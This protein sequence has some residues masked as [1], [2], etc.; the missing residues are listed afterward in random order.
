M[1]TPR[2]D[3]GGRYTWDIAAEM[4]QKHS[5][6]HLTVAGVLI[7]RLNLHYMLECIHGHKR[8]RNYCGVSLVTDKEVVEEPLWLPQTSDNDHYVTSLSVASSLEE[9]LV[10]LDDRRIDKFKAVVD[11]A[12]SRVLGVATDGAYQ[13]P[14]GMFSVGQVNYDTRFMFRVEAHGPHLRLKVLERFE[15]QSVLGVNTND[16]RFDT[17][18][19]VLTGIFSVS[20]SAI[21]HP[22]TPFIVALFTSHNW[23]QV[24][25]AL[26]QLLISYAHTAGS[27]L[28]QQVQDLIC[29][30]LVMPQSAT[31]FNSF[32]SAA[33]V[34]MNTP[35]AKAVYVLL[36]A[37]VGV[38]FGKQVGFQFVD[39]KNMFV[40]A[41]KTDV[42]TVPG[43]IAAVIDFG[44]QVLDG[45]LLQAF[46]TRDFSI[47]GSNLAT[48]TLD[49]EK[50]LRTLPQEQSGEPG[51]TTT[52]LLDR[53]GNLAQQWSKQAQ[54]TPAA[55]SNARAQIERLIQRK[56]H[57]SR[58]YVVN[59]GMPAMIV[60]VAGDPGIGKS[61]ICV[62]GANA[63]SNGRRAAEG[64][65]YKPEL[66]CEQI[67][68]D[69]KAK[70]QP[71]YYSAISG[72]K[73]RIDDPVTL[74]VNVPVSQQV[75]A[76]TLDAIMQIGDKNGY[77]VPGADLASKEN[78]F[79]SVE[80]LFVSMNPVPLAS[81][82]QL[83]ATP[84]ALRRRVVVMKPQ[85][86]I[87]CMNSSMGLNREYARE[88]PNEDYY[89]NV[90]ITAAG[91]NGAISTVTCRDMGA[92]LLHLAKLSQVHFT[93][94]KA[95]NE[96][97]KCKTRC[98][99]CGMPITIASTCQHV[100]REP[101]TC[102]DFTSAAADEPMY[103]GQAP[104]SDVGLKEAKHLYYATGVRGF[105]QVA[106][107]YLYHRLMHSVTFEIPEIFDVFKTPL[108][109][110]YLALGWHFPLFG[111]LAPVAFGW[112]Y[113]RFHESAKLPKSKVL[114]LAGAGVLSSVVAWYTVTSTYGWLKERLSVAKVVVQNSATLFSTQGG[115]LGTQRGPEPPKLYATADPVVAYTGD[116][117]TRRAAMSTLRIGFYVDGALRVDAYATRVGN[118]CFT[119][120]HTLAPLK[121]PRFAPHEQVE[122]VITTPTRPAQV[123]RYVVSGQQLLANDLGDD[124]C[125]LPFHV[126]TS[127]VGQVGSVT[128]RGYLVA[129][130]VDGN[131]N[132][133]PVRINTVRQRIFLDG[134][135]VNGYTYDRQG[136]GLC[137]AC[138]C[139]DVGEP[140]GLH[141]AGTPSLGERDDGC[142]VFVPITKMRYGSD[143]PVMHTD[144]PLSAKT[145]ATV[146]D[147]SR[148]L[149]LGT[150]GDR[151]MNIKTKFI[152]ANP[153]IDECPVNSKLT[154]P[155]RK[156]GGMV[157]EDGSMVY[158]NPMTHVLR[159][160]V[161]PS[162][163]VDR[164]VIDFIRLK[165][166]STEEV[167]KEPY[168][169]LT[170]H[171]A[172]NG[173]YSVDGTHKHVPSLN[174]N[175]S[176]GK[177]F[178]GGKKA[179]LT[180]DLTTLEWHA[181]N[182]LQQAY[183]RIED[184]A[185]NGVVA[186]STLRAALKD[187]PLSQSKADEFRTR[188]FM[189][190]P[191]AWLLLCR[192]YLGTMVE[193]LKKLAYFAVGMNVFQEWDELVKKLISFGAIGMGDLERFDLSNNG[194]LILTILLELFGWYIRKYGTLNDRQSRILSTVLDYLANPTVEYGGDLYYIFGINGSGS[195]ITTILNCFIVLI[196]LLT[197]CKNEGV[198]LDEL[199]AKIFGDDHVYNLPGSLTQLS[200]ARAATQYGHT[201]TSAV[202]GQE[203]TE[204][205][206]PLGLV[207]LKR[208]AYMHED[209]DVYVPALDEQSIWKML[210]FI[211]VE[212]ALGPE[213]IPT[214]VANFC[215]EFAL[216]GRE[217]FDSVVSSLN[218]AYR[219]H[220]V[221][222]DVCIG[223]YRTGQ[224]ANELWGEQF[225]QVLGAT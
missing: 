65:T 142:G 218:P 183:V 118:S 32:V 111:L 147:E 161:K 7:G 39:V 78:S 198:P 150:D 51:Y 21:V 26:W 126:P 95:Q 134:K 186:D 102:Y 216:H 79:D 58:T 10:D 164:D 200:V 210:L 202:K 167:H 20:A 207:F 149:Y 16:P 214:S 41:L 132:V 19:D 197:A 89:E 104:S 29:Q 103:V 165:I 46:T 172:I 53:I 224:Y 24:F 1:N 77:R 143:F 130:D 175:T 122:V 90:E 156:Q 84:D 63:V 66:E 68:F 44:V 136:A 191:F 139:N 108:T 220:V 12:T 193:N 221:P 109:V 45:T 178:P 185:A 86:K 115:V 137:G 17:L 85:L 145:G 54:A 208:S 217:K 82:F 192:A 52:E 60:I 123:N 125:Q 166:D 93:N 18:M 157:S 138:V 61:T 55:A 170:L 22:V 153:C 14:S 34:L 80:S 188:I 168:R 222:Y 11:F 30:V 195:N 159:R 37:V 177:F 4:P 3:I 15:S 133:S 174:V 199:F 92:A 25:V 209:L 206:N 74:K 181:S 121:R 187:E 116:V 2:I 151:G 96:R 40:S 35:A 201:Y 158:K 204:R 88:H 117:I 194:E 205:V 71:S 155:K 171:E 81:L 28:Y 113:A 212:S 47:L 160:E 110:G 49:T 42:D 9:F 173:T 211:N 75:I 184:D 48:L 70:Y 59:D 97:I 213:Q 64:R 69:P 144:L 8:D 36:T 50:V 72:Q 163:L 83:H 23:T 33:S 124:V 107:Y 196:I 114:A 57:L 94:A 91:V 127:G 176:G 43:A 135:W 105:V 223:K 180:Q 98:L 73:L 203:L 100:A 87:Q 67:S 99:K 120:M 131:P 129:F 141:A 31:S 146:V 76:D 219:Q 6:T 62:D 190:M 179:W 215:M 169:V 101:G 56:Q 154:V 182:E 112:R 148:A 106:K 225:L 119:N 27:L 5:R 152:P 189:V 38:V 140:L 128:E 13:L 162:S